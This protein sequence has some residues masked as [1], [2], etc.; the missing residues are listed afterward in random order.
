[1][2]LSRR[3][4]CSAAIFSGL[5]VGLEIAGRLLPVPSPPS[6]LPAHP[7][8]G[9]SL[10]VA[11]SFSFDGVPATTNSLGLRSPEPTQQPQ[12]RILTLGDSSVFGHGVAD[13]ETFAAVLAARTGADVQNGGCPATPAPSRP[14]A[15][16]RWSRR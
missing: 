11:Q 16:P 10:P 8:R 2:S 12:L 13:D 3:L 6:E 7:Q 15:T 4:G 9:W 14:C 5:L 1:M